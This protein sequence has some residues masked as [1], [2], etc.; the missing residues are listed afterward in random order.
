M[1]RFRELVALIQAEYSC[2]RFFANYD[3]KLT[4]P[5][6]GDDYR[7]YER[8]L[9]FLDPESWAELRTK[10]VKHF[11]DQRPGQ[12]KQGFFN[13]L[14]DA[15]AYRHLV[16]RG[17]RQVRVLRENSKTQPDLEYFDGCERLFCE[18]KTLGL[19]DLEIAR[20][21]VPRRFRSSIYYQLDECFLSKLR[22]TLDVAQNQISAR[23]SGMVYL[24]MH[25]DDFTLEHYDNYRKQV[26]S[27]LQ[28]HT[29]NNVYVQVGLRGRRHIE[30]APK[31][32]GSGLHI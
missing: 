27:C 1:D 3:Q 12:L 25:F 11:M 29:A 7:T 24:I 21:H 10:A 31:N 17:Y 8:T 26:H 19:S 9:H 2:D 18:V 23:G 30:K 14:N 13:Q 6:L 4:V 20:R 16:R 28:E 15:F 32:T 22:S 5:E